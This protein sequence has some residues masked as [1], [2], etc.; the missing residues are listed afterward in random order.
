M[1]ILAIDDEKLALDLLAICLKESGYQDFTS[2]SD[3]ELAM[4]MII[5]EKP[6]F[7]CI[8]LDISMPGR[9]GLDLCRDIRSIERYR[10]VPIIMITGKADRPNVDAAFA[11]GA[12]DYVTK[13]FD[14][15]EVGHR[16][17]LAEAMVTE[18]KAAM[19]SY[20]AIEAVQKSEKPALGRLAARNS[21][22]WIEGRHLIGQAEL[23]NYLSQITKSSQR[24]AEI[25]GVRIID[26]DKLFDTLEPHEF[27]EVVDEVAGAITASVDKPNTLVSL[28]GNGTFICTIGAPVRENLSD[29]EDLISAEC[30][31]RLQ[32]RFPRLS[33]QLLATEPFQFSI[34]TRSYPNLDRIRKVLFNRANTRLQEKLKHRVRS[35]S[36]G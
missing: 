17:R 22:A 15:F 26:I 1:K 24:Y 32:R 18:R 8:L 27:L 34:L 7:D 29:L 14:A 25:F 4:R 12:T 6:E 30:A 23:Q 33:I 36:A 3:P 10:H 11:R 20:L 16:I 9:S 5:R 19:D 28:L 31:A 35:A 13:P 2:Y 21:H